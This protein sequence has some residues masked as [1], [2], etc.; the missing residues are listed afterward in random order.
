M[1]T[2]KL[3]K[4]F[5]DMGSLQIITEGKDG[6]GVKFKGPFLQSE[7]KNKNGR[8]YSKGLYTREVDL[9][10]KEKISKS[11]AMG[12]LDHPPSPVVNLSRVSHNIE[13][14][15]MEGNDGNGEAKILD[16]PM[17]RIAS[18]LIKG[19]VVLGVSTRGVGTIGKGNN[20]NEDYKLITVDLVADPSAPNSF[21][22]GILENKEFIMDGDNIVEVSIDQLKKKMDKGRPSSNEVLKYVQSFL[23]DIGKGI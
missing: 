20:V 1:K 23:Y 5:V 3:L 15:V 17:G 2:L 6:K 19:G 4:E 22:D 13:S 12:E 7:V 9:F 14:L 18:S 11:R 21:V 8:T 16:T 10:N